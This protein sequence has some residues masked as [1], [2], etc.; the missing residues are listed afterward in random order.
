M[1][2][3]FQTLRQPNRQPAQSPWTQGGIQGIISSGGGGAGSSAGAGAGVENAYDKTGNLS[4][5]LSR[6][7]IDIGPQPDFWGDLNSIVSRLRPR[8]TQPAAQQAQALR[9]P[10]AYSGP[11][12]ERPAGPTA[13]YNP[14]AARFA[15]LTRFGNSNAYYQPWQPG[16]SIG[17]GNA[18]VA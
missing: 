18:P 17:G 11:T 2:N 6:E 9:A 7:G 3:M 8:A 13:M 12:G 16:M 10:A 5:I 1:A 15:Q 4:S 14:D